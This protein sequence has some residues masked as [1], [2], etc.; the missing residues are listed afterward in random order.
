LIITIDGPSGAGKGTVCYLLAK[1]FNF[2][3]LDS[4]A[5]YR[6]T[7]LSAEN[8][9][10]DFDDVEALSGVAKNLDVVFAPQESGVQIQLDGN[11]VTAL[12]R[13]E[14]VGMNA[15]KVA[16]CNPVREALLQRQRDFAQAPGLVADGRDMGTTV[17]PEAQLKIFLTASAD[18]RA[19]RRVLQL[20]GTGEV[21]NYDQI[22]LD[23]EQRD[24][25]DTNR[26]VSPLKPAVDAVIIDCTAMSV[27]EVLS[28]ISTRAN[29]I[30]PDVC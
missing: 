4:G 29:K 12:I 22:L 17:F 13:Q 18:E 1:K 24:E 15:S 11:D 27:D 6:L 14:H 23:I 3:L 28:E 7:A 5:L 8:K 9:Q 25:Q 26:S 2:H 21:A 19:K 10:V 16:G 20:E 30:M